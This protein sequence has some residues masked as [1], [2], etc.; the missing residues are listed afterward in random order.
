MVANVVI[1]A[2]VLTLQKMPKD[3]GRTAEALAMGAMSAGGAG[4]NERGRREDTDSFPES[5]AH[6]AAWPS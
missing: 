2:S 5:Q 1:V 6:H 4:G 3:V